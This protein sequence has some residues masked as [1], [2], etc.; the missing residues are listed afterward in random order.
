MTAFRQIKG[1]SFST[2]MLLP[3]AAR[4]RVAACG[5]APARRHIADAD[6]P[7]LPYCSEC[8]S[9]FAWL[10]LC[11]RDH[12]VQFAKDPISREAFARPLCLIT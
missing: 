2:P 10:G 12:F 11:L 5:R 4:A 7:A 9:S 8:N 1:N 6:R 3:M